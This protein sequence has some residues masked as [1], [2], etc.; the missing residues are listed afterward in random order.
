MESS[1]GV[2]EVDL[3]FIGF[4]DSFDGGTPHDTGT[5]GRQN[6]ATYRPQVL[7]GHTGLHPGAGEWQFGAVKRQ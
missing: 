5:D 1:I 7:V 3:V 4:K 6:S 2:E